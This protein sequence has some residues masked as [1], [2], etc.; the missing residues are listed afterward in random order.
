MEIRYIFPT[1]DKYEVSNVYEQSWKCAYKYII[2]Q[3]YLDGISVG[4]WVEYLCQGKS[5]NLVVVENDTIIGT[6][7]FSKS[8]F[9]KYKN[10]GEII[11]IYFL[12]EYIAKGYG[13]LLLDRTIKELKKLG[14]MRILLWVL[15]DNHKA[16]R[17]YEKYRFV[18]SGE[19][20]LVNIGGKDLKEIMYMYQV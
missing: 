17:F 13:K 4:H 8:R 10:Y 5:H 3:P 16:R 12:P 1:D 15:E 19:E 2:P 20:M 9:A 6:S 18:L 11:S 7:S 14:Y